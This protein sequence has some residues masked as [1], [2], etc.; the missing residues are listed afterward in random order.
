MDYVIALK[1]FVKTQCQVWLLYK[2][3]SPW[4]D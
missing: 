1:R 3:R 4:V 2:L